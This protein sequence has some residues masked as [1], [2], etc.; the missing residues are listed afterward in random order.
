M[1]RAT[2]LALCALL[3]LVSGVIAA[4]GMG[5]LRGIVHDPQHRPIPDAQITVRAKG[6]SWSKIL[7]SNANGEFETGSIPVGEYVVT[8]TASGFHPLT[9]TRDVVEGNSPVVHFWMDLGRTRQ[10]VKV[11]GVPSLLNTQSATTQTLV[12]AK[13]ITRTP[14]A[15]L[16]NSLAMITDFVPGAYMVHDQ[17]HLRGGHQTGWLVD[18]V[19]VPNTNI[20][21]NV[22]PLISPRD[23]SSLQV[24]RGGYSAEYGDRTFGLFNVVT[25]SGFN[26]NNEGDLVL[27]Y[28]SFN[29][30]DD[31][32]NFGSHSVRTAYYVSLDGN[33]SD[34]G[35]LTPTPDVIHGRE[36]GLG[37]F[38]SFMFNAS[39]KNQFRLVGSLRG[40][41]YQIPNT[42]EQQQAGIRDLDRER[43]AFL[44]FSWVHAFSEGALLTVSPFFHY[45]SADYIGGPKDTPF[46]LNQNRA[47]SYPGIQATLAGTQ[48]KN[49]F[50]FGS[51]IFGQ[52]DSTLFSLRASPAGNS[53]AQSLR[54]WGNMEAVFAGDRYE[55]APWLSFNGGVRFTRFSGLGTETATDPRVGAAL[56]VPHL[57][58]ILRGYFAAYYQP[59]PLD[60]ISGPLLEF[61]LNEG[62]GFLPLRGERDRQR[63]FGVSIPFRHWLVDVDNFYTNAQNFFDHDELGNSNIFLP[64]TIQAARI[65]G[66]EVTL[67]SPQL[68]HRLEWRV[69][70]SNQIAQALGAMT[71]G[72]TD[73][74]PPEPGYFFLDHD[75]RNT[76]SNVVSVTLPRASW[77]SVTY[78][79]G[80]GF[81]DGDGPDHLPSHSVVDLALG[82]TFAERWTVTLNALNLTNAR[83]L[84]DN[85]NTFG[86]THY[87]GPR[88]IYVEMRVRF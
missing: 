3:V 77:A 44:N 16:T 59:P 50:L 75:Q 37:G 46:V 67:R 4:T 24:Q 49:H 45:N 65:R 73:F 2:L 10:Q 62:V 58:W 22:G 25:P 85:S 84:L 17:L 80:S 52:H 86:G 47:S 61:A 64:L 43:D 87:A 63:D 15:T 68:F 38:G 48:G 28:G 79:Y 9:E 12:S 53:L 39:A 7:R 11:S 18:G 33:R 34:L 21:S 57:G 5:N 8:V 35:L 40:D 71:G 6:S 82:K 81:L 69:A 31:Q 54:P 14:G 13:E 19:P 30:T 66:T 78:G 60:T 76:L 41:Q 74:S 51:E 42:P 23:I 55:V 26:R 27:S 36:A 1:R 83:F 20:A 70:Y 56:R 88:Q 32:I 72:L 29:R